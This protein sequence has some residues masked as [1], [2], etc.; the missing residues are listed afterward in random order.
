MLLRRVVA[1]IEPPLL[2]LDPATLA[3]EE[4][5]GVILQYPDPIPPVLHVEVRTQ[6]VSRAGG[7]RASGEGA[8]AYFCR[9]WESHIVYVGL[10]YCLAHSQPTPVYCG[11]SPVHAAEVCRHGHRSELN[12]ILQA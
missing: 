7:Y 6:A 11:L 2:H 1:G 8:G 10:V 3:P 5:V 9:P 12:S 4:G